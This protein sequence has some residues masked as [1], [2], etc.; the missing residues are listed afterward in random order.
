MLRVAGKKNNATSSWSGYNHQGQV[1][2]FLALKE[3]RVLLQKSKDYNDYSVEFETEDGEDV[4]IVQSNTVI[5]RHQ[6]KAK[7]TSKNLNA[8]KDV[9]ERFNITDVGEDSSIM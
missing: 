6:V 8:Y 5:S 7:T 1:G 4:D 2:I 3:P 9:L